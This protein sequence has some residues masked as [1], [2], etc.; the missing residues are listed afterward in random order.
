MT[1]STLL[2]WILRPHFLFKS[3][4]AWK[5]YVDRR[6]ALSSNFPVLYIL[7]GS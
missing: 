7:E 4:H 5:F 6:P 2:G 3:R 1:T